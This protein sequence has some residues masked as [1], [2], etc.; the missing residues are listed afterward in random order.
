[1]TKNAPRL[2]ELESNE[3][4]WDRFFS[5]YP[6]VVIGTLDEDGTYD[7]APKHLAMPL[8]WGSDF[9]FVCTPRHRTYQNIRR[10]GEFCVTYARPSQ[11]VL[12]SLAASPRCDDDS[13]PIVNALPTVPSERVAG[14]FLEDGYACLDCR[15]RKIY[16]DFGENSLIAGE[17]L[18]ARVAEDALKHADKDDQDLIAGAPLLA[19]LYPGRFAE[20]SSSNRLPFPSGFKR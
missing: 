3:R 2:V 10:T 9:G 6:L 4:I 11:I 12:A 17:V 5:V 8:S 19:Y 20:I 1:M 7:L 15:C 13:K 18:A 16:D 14:A